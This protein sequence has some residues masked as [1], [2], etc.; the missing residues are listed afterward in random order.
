MYI[1]MNRFRVHKD[2]ETVF[3]TMWKERDSHLHEVPGFQ[4]FHLLKGPVDGEGTLY[5]THTI[6]ESH[7]A[8]QD[9]TQSESF[10]KA[11]K[12]ARTRQ[13]NYLGHPQFEGFEVILEQT[14]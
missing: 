1:A 2:F 13:V 12:K 4:E 7:T 14:K 3:E 9:W 11:H 10:R 8:F 5:A 6:W